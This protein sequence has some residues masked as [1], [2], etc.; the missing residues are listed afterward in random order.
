MSEKSLGVVLPAYQIDPNQLN[1][2]L[3]EL[4]NQLS[5]KEIILEYDKPKYAEEIEG[6]VN[7]QSFDSRR[8]KGAAIKHGFNMLDTDILLFSDSDGSVPTEIYRK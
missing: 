2:Y 5:P 6:E 7:I 1:N 3:E 4:Q 8:G